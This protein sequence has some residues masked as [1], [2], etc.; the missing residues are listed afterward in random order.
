MNTARFTAKDIVAAFFDPKVAC[1]VCAQQILQGEREKWVWFKGTE[2][3]LIAI[4]EPTLTGKSFPFMQGFARNPDYK[5]KT[6]PPVQMQFIV[7]NPAYDA[8]LAKE[9][10]EAAKY[11]GMWMS[12]ARWEQHGRQVKAGAKSHKLHNT[13][14]PLG[15]AV[16]LFAFSDTM[17]TTPEPEKTITVVRPADWS[18][19]ADF[20]K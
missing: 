17:S 10:E 11:A 15:Q 13:E 4:S 19:T 2:N 9:Q 14:Y 8:W 6:V 1:A 12:Y 16:G 18:N 5:A 7:P 3:S 20:W